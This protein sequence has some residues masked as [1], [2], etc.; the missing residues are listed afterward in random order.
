MIEN[1]WIWDNFNF[2]KTDF[3]KKLTS[4]KNGSIFNFFA[5]EEYE[6][7]FNDGS[8]GWEPLREI[9]LKK[10]NITVNLIFSG[11]NKE[12]YDSKYKN[13]SQI[14]LWPTFFINRSAYYLKNYKIPNRAYKYLF[15]SMNN[16]P[17]THRC[18]LIDNIK[19]YNLDVNSALTWYYTDVD[20]DW[21]HWK[22][23]QLLLSDTQYIA[24]HKSNQ[25]N[26]QLVPSIHNVPLEFFQ[27]WVSVVSE[28]SVDH[29]FLTEKTA[30][31]LLLEQPF[32]VQGAKGF[33]QML[34]SLGFEL[35]DEIFDYSFDCLECA[36]A[37]TDK[38]IENMLNLKFKNIDSLKDQLINKAKRN[39]KT[40]LAIA[41]NKNLV[42]AMV[43][44]TEYSKN[45]YSRELEF[46]K[47][48]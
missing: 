43:L 15:I 14:H 45:I 30:I 12:Y 31:P 4:A 9:N 44:N 25:I 27:S 1:N 11:F 38:I 42:P 18:Y 41:A 7:K 3:K 47:L 5:A 37:R 23:T 16:L 34:K 48:S 19:K 26:N 33:H 21:K 32:I 20:Y 40:A 2:D 24:Y 22:P 8:R 46:I 39:R 36:F 28:S 13:N 17:R 10:Q 35:Y 6:I 29:E